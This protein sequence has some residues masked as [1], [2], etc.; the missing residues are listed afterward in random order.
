MK[1][2]ASIVLCAGQGTRMKSARAKVLHE[3][4]GHPLGTW[5][6]RRALEIGASPVVAVVGHQAEEVEKA[7]TADLAGAP[8]RFALQKEQ[9]GTAHAVLCGRP[10]LG[11]FSGEVLVLYGDTPLVRRETLSALVKVKRSSRSPVALVTMTAPDPR[12]Y[13]RI[14][15]DGAGQAW[16][17]I[18]DKDCT[19]EQRCID[20]LN[21]GMYLVDSDFLWKAL[22]QV[23]RKNAQ[24]EFYL[25]DLVEMAFDQG[26]P[27]A[28]LCVP[29]EEVAGVNDRVE[30]ARATSVLRRRINQAHMRAGVTLDDPRTVVIE[31]QV[32]IGPDTRIAPNVVLTGATVVGKDVRIGV[33]CVVHNSVIAD[34]ARLHPYCS[35]DDAKVGREALIGP[36]ARLRPGTDLAAKVHVGNFVETKKAKI[37][38]GSKAN[39]LTYLGDCEIGAG[40]NVGAGTITCNYDGVNKHKTTIGDGVFVGSDS[41]FVAPVT[42]GRGTYIGSGSTITDDIPPDSLAIA[43]S[44]QVT[45]PGYMKKKKKAGAG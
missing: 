36:F 17:I 31:E 35:L 25:T 27:A 21:A 14:V 32:R 29:I 2:L 22:K 8:V 45:K 9:L 42:I 44:R 33:G 19:P 37:G 28:T 15:R 18:E 1:S 23:G 7:F 43:R 26:T 40:V 38:K 41:Q 11:R 10:G 24:R 13:G 6:I 3:V 34:G 5:S 12:G 39:H 4:L 20:E 16:H 30:L